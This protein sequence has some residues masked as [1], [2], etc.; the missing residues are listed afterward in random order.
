MTTSNSDRPT[1]LDLTLTAQGSR[2]SVL[3]W[4]GAAALAAIA[5]GVRIPGLDLRQA[6]AQG[7][8]TD[9]G[10][11]DIGV[12]N[13]AYALEQL[14]AGFYSMVVD[15]PYSDM[16]AMEAELLR[17]IRDHEVAHRDFFKEALGSNAIPM[18][19]ADF[20]AV[21]FSSRESVLTT[22]MTFEDLGVSAYNGGGQYIENP[23]YLLAAGRIVSVEARHAAIIRDLLQ[24]NTIAFA[25]ADI[26]DKNGLDLAKMPSEVLAAADPFIKTAVTAKELP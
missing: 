1:G 13:Y 21:D 19:E 22:A 14:E 15:M 5:S 2:R 23:D 26:I 20:S 3:K 25:G 17:D 8:A 6:L 7:M 4:T 10:S 12:L 9:L 16:P 24:P 18:L 11:G